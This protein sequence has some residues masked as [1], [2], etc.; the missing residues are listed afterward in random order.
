MRPIWILP[1]IL[2]A[3]RDLKWDGTFSSGGDL[4]G[5]SFPSSYR[6]ASRTGQLRQDGPAEGLERVGIQRSEVE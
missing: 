3:W 2:C 1:D 5:D 4:N 6:Q